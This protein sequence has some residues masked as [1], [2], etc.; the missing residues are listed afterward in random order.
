MP[1]KE[2]YR[3]VTF[4][5]SSYIHTHMHTYIHTYK[6]TYIHTYIYIHMHRSIHTN[7][8]TYTHTY[9][10]TCIDRRNLSPQYRWGMSLYVQYTHTYTHACM[11]AY[12]NTY[13][14]TYTHM[15]RSAKPSTPVS[16]WL[17][18]ACHFT[19]N[20]CACAKDGGTPRRQTR[21]L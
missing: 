8:H 18:R 4:Q 19:C 14:H 11:P 16:V 13:T 12:I 6:R 10:Y 2:P 5:I 20:K 15:H 3:T 9:T 1:T 17:Q 21:S 7:V